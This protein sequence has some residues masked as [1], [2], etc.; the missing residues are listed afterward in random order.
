MEL[1]SDRAQKYGVAMF[2]TFRAGGWTS[3]CFNMNLDGGEL[4]WS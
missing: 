1:L 4:S 3:V 2:G